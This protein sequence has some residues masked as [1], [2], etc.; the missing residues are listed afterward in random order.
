M[1]LVIAIAF[2]AAIG[3]AALVLS[4]ARLNARPPG[5]LDVSGD[6]Q[7]RPNRQRDAA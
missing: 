5:L 4:A 1:W 2:L 7:E 3:A 6:E